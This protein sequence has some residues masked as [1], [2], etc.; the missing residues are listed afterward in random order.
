MSCMLECPNQRQRLSVLQYEYSCIN[1]TYTGHVSFEHLTHL[2]ISYFDLVSRFRNS[3][4]LGLQ[5]GGHPHDPACFTFR[6]AGRV[7]Q[8]VTSTQQVDFSYE[9]PHVHRYWGVPNDMDAYGVS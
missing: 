9:V 7:A 3:L 2:L 1:S 4:H 5:A 6:P 8:R